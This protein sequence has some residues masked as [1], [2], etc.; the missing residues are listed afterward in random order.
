MKGMSI[1]LFKAIGTT[2]LPQ[3][4]K[5]QIGTPIIQSIRGE[6]KANT[7][8]SFSPSGWILQNGGLY[9]IQIE[10]ENY[11]IDTVMTIVFKYTRP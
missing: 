9:G 6:I 7:T 11:P 3:P 2:E 5:G 10:C 8:A 4:T 1:R